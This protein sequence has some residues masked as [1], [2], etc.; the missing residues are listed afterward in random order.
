MN[1]FESEKLLRFLVINCHRGDR[2]GRGNNGEHLNVG[3]IYEDEIVLTRGF[4]F[5]FVSFVVVREV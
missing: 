3:L 1:N 2:R 5:V 4:R